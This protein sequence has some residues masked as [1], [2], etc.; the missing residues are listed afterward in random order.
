MKWLKNPMANAIYVAG[1]TAIY[2]AVFIVS[3]EF[4]DSYSSLLSGSWWAS[5]ITSQSM[6]FVG[7]GMIGGAI[8]VDILSAFRKR[9][10]DEYQ[11]VVLEKV[12]LFNGMFTA[13][14][15]PLSLAVLALAPAYFVEA[16]F[17]LVL[18]QWAVMMTTELLYLIIN[19][20][21]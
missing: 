20:K 4:T 8:A 19:Y 11:I 14:A 18:V 16:V 10:Y 13:V 6:K 12:F 9:G 1:I 3:S 21:I 2:A 15:F 5:F 7:I 17:A